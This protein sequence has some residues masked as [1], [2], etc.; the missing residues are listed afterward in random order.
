MSN[1]GHTLLQSP[2]FTSCWRKV[3]EVRFMRCLFRTRDTAVDQIRAP[4]ISVLRSLTAIGM[5]FT[6]CGRVEWNARCWTP[7]VCLR[8]NPYPLET[9][10]LP[11]Y[12]GES[13]TFCSSAGFHLNLVGER[14]LNFAS[15]VS[16]S[17]GFAYDGSG[18][19]WMDLITSREMVLNEAR[20]RLGI[21]SFFRS[22]SS[23][24]NF[25]VCFLCLFFLNYF[26]R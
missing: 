13:R 6:C 12:G 16:L 14:W 10:W 20:P 2:I 15:R 21:G 7:N 8:I 19:I 3:I 1:G 5:Y 9:L 26:I 11:E 23:F 17:R 18:W 4:N 25:F 24:S 22:I